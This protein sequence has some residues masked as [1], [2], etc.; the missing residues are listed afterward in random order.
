MLNFK[1]LIAT[2]IFS[3]FLLLINTQTVKAQCP[4]GE[5]EVTISF[6]NEDNTPDE[7]ATLQWNY[8]AGGL[9]SNEGPFAITDPQTICVPEGELLLT[10]CGSNYYAYVNTKAKVIFTEDG[11]VNGC[12]A[13]NGCP[14]DIENVSDAYNNYGFYSLFPCEDMLNEP[15]FSVTV[16]CDNSVVHTEGCT[17]TNAPNY[18]PCAIED[19][20]TCEIQTSNNDCSN[21]I[22]LTI[23]PDV[24]STESIPINNVFNTASGLIP[25]CFY[26]YSGHPAT[27]VFFQVEV[28]ASGNIELSAGGNGGIAFYDDCGGTELFCEQAGSYYQVY[29]LPPGETII[30]QVWQNYQP[31]F[32]NIWAAALPATVPNDV[33]SNSTQLCG[34]PIFENNEGAL[35]EANEPRVFYLERVIH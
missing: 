8:I 19:D 14:A 7:L 29:G 31:S 10:I 24:F 28:P 11:S 15:V 9:L 4:T 5:T 18:N 1:K 2:T 21:A 20:G 12:G 16:G 33:C 6:I 17:N 13:Q 35:A 25:S 30:L 3:F 22:P 26:S 27:D 32:W 34:V 23:S